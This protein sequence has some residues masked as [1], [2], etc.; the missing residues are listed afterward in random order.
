MGLIHEIEIKNAI[1]MTWKIASLYEEA[2]WCLSAIESFL[3]SDVEGLLG[4]AEESIATA[5][6]SSRQGKMMYIQYPKRS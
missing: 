2:L 3:F 1:F 6:E 5:V 4:P